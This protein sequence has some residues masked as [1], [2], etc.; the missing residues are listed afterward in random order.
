MV[1]IRVDSLIPSARLKK[2]VRETANLI[3]MA[4]AKAAIEGRPLSINFNA[5]DRILTLEY[6]FETEEDREYYLEQMMKEKEDDYVEDF[7]EE[8]EPIFKLKWEKE[9]SIHTIE[10]QA[11]EE[12]VRDYIIFK[13]EGTS[14][15]ATMIWSESSGLYQTMHLWPLL[16]KVEI[17][18]LQKSPLHGY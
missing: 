17:L 3:E 9:I 13:P 12:E 2:Q 11:S 1:I 6:Y 10:V 8:I 5:D 14:D 16:G 18:P 15:G 7:S 4:F